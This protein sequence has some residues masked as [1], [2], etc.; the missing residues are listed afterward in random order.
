MITI[1]GRKFAKNNA[2][3]TSSLFVESG[4]CFGFY[5]KVR[6]GCR[7]YN[8]QNELFAF[9]ANNRH[10]E[11]FFVSASIHDGKPWYMYAL[12]D[13]DERFLGFDSMSLREEH[14]IAASV[15]EAMQ[16]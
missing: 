2:E 6:G 3:F 14:A 16:S 1:N 15:F 9:I 7:L 4:T 8:M 5:K 10:G 13:K 11:R 12:T